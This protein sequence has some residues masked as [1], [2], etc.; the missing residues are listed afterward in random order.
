MGQHF[1]VTTDREGF[2]EIAHE[3][4]SVTGFALHV[5]QAFD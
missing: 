3:P 5:L 1:T 2:R 4:G